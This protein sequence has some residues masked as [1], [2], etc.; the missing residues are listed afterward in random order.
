MDGSLFEFDT[1]ALKM[2]KFF[3]SHSSLI[4]C[5][6][7]GIMST[8]WLVQTI[9]GTIYEKEVDTEAFDIGFP[10]PDYQVKQFSCCSNG[11][12]QFILL[13]NNRLFIRNIGFGFMNEGNAY[14]TKELKLSFTCEIKKI[15][16]GF[17]HIALLLEDGQIFCRG[18]NSSN[19]CGLSVGASG[20]VKEFQ[21]IQ[22]EGPFKDVYCTSVSTGVK[23]DTHFCIAQIPQE[24]I[25]DEQEIIVCGPWH[26]YIY[27][28]TFTVAKSPEE[29][30]FFSL[31]RRQLSNSTFY[32][33]SFITF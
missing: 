12:A 30:F 11:T 10:L 9:D 17:A 28:K 26:G 27:R 22:I 15:D 29:I 14:Q 3:I 21:R 16:T 2:N 25:N 23:T 7:S 5:V 13:K 1:Q 6:G 32:D 31:L 20:P 19:Q 24:A 8:C 18:L 33:L 4:H